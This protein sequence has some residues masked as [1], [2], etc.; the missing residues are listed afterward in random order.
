MSSGGL[1][2]VSVVASVLG[3]A[4]IVALVIISR[5][6]C[7]KRKVL[8]QNAE[9]VQ[10]QGAL[11]VR[12]DDGG[13]GGGGSGGSGEGTHEADVSMYYA[14]I[15]DDTKSITPSSSSPQLQLPLPVAKRRPNASPLFDATEASRGSSVIYDD[16][17]DGVTPVVAV[18]TPHPVTPRMSSLRAISRQP[19]MNMPLTSASERG[20][21]A[22]I[23]GIAELPPPAPVPFVALPAPPATPL[24]SLPSSTLTPFSQPPHMQRGMAT[25]TDPPASTGWS[26][27]FSALGFFSPSPKR[28]ALSP[29]PLQLPGGA[30]G[31]VGAASL[32]SPTASVSITSP[33]AP[34]FPPRGRTRLAPDAALAASQ[35]LRMPLRP[36]LGHIAPQLIDT[37]GRRLVTTFTGPLGAAPGVLNHRATS[38]PRPGI[39]VTI[40]PPRR[41]SVVDVRLPPS[42]EYGSQ[43]SSSSP[44]G[45]SAPE[46]LAGAVAQQRTARSINVR[47]ASA[48]SRPGTQAPLHAQLAPLAPLVL[49]SPPA[50]LPPSARTGRQPV[51][52]FA[53]AAVVSAALRVAPPHLG[54]SSRLGAAFTISQRALAEPV[55][56]AAAA[57]AAAATAASD[58]GRGRVIRPPLPVTMGQQGGAPPTADASRGRAVHVGVVGASAMPVRAAPSRRI[59]STDGHSPASDVTSRE[60]RLSVGSASSSIKSRSPRTGAMGPT[61]SSL[62]H[63]RTPAAASGAPPRGGVQVTSPSSVPAAVN[64]ARV[65]SVAPPASPAAIKASVGGLVSPTAVQRPPLAASLAKPRPPSG[66]PPTR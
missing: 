65:F 52:P 25:P 43:S 3:C 10:P 55:S 51:P 27:V 56:V 60:R 40:S 32:R 66:P 38:V 15:D 13:S 6:Q 2:A 30:Q 54:D 64:A 31:G 19:S 53:A 46:V 47:L 41:S 12:V 61:L 21:V 18:S 63:A 28:G 39:S 48:Q 42:L 16:V 1:I 8:R 23:S 36:V 37:D 20:L 9:S 4:I 11:T 26:N 24:P 49:P 29:T 7:E 34:P 45:L 44:T 17:V 22:E 14:G 33:S 62:A 59:V 58:L 5:K 57:A 35:L 50:T